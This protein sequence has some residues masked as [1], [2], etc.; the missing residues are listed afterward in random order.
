VKLPIGMPPRK[1]K[2]NTGPRLD[3][4]GYLN[5][6]PDIPC[7][8]ASWVGLPIGHDVINDFSEDANGA[9]VAVVRYNSVQY[10]DQLISVGDAVYLTPEEQGEACEICEITDL[11][12]V[13]DE[14]N[15]KRAT[16]QW[17][18]RSEALDLPE[19][20]LVGKH[21]I[22]GTSCTDA[23]QSIDAIERCLTGRTG[24]AHQPD[25]H[26]CQLCAHRSCVS[27][28]LAFAGSSS[29]THSTQ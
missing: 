1:K 21:E 10:G 12:E 14:D 22:F 15:P 27:A 19:E 24:H 6:H 7:P 28:P 29:S 25:V 23:H 13:E 8:A 4:V 20:E 3:E 17:F 2:Q 11:Y 26:A 9:E 5:H 18:W 16:V